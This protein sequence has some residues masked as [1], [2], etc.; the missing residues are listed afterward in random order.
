MRS[1]H[2]KLDDTSE[3]KLLGEPRGQQLAC[4]PTKL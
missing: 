1:A 3:R 2:S 4:V